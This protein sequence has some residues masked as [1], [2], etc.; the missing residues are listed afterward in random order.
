VAGAQAAASGAEEVEAGE[1]VAVIVKAEQLIPGIIFQQC[2]VAFLKPAELP[3]P[4]LRTGSFY[5]IINP[6]S[7]VVILNPSTV[8]LNEVKNLVVRLR[9]NSVKDLVTV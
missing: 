2:M 8:I 4:F 5:C 7:I 6:T 1:G 3:L 9:I